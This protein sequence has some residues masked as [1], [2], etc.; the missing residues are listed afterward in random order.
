MFHTADDSLYE[1]H[2]RILGSRFNLPSEL[3][4]TP[5]FYLEHPDLA[6]QKGVDD[7]EQV[8]SRGRQWLRRLFEE[9]RLIVA[10]ING[11]APTFPALGRYFTDIERVKQLKKRCFVAAGPVSRILSAALLLRDDHSS[12]PRIAARL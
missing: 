11:I 2:S 8:L 6:R 10:D 9:E 12:G 1:R 5:K 4:E 3:F 7:F